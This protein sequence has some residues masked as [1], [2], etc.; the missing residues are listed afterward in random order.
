MKTPARLPAKLEVATMIARAQASGGIAMVLA[1]GEP[2]SGTIAVVA[3]DRS[4]LGTL[5][6]R[7]PDA[8]GHRRWTV[9]RQQDADSRADFDAYL[10]RRARQDSDLWIVELT[11]ADVERSILNP[12]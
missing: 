6:E 10:E 2:D 11:V 7:V 1:R 4:G 12:D 8:S 3:L 9:V 5:Y